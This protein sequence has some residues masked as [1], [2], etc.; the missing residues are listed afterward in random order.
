MWKT[1]IKIKEAADFL[2]ISVS[3]L[4]K[5]GKTGKLIAQRHP[6]NKYRLYRFSDLSNFTK[7]LGPKKHR[8]NK[9]Q[10]VDE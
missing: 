9:I 7:R 10:L 2:G 4:R 6:I 8:N 1:Y 5:W 3:T